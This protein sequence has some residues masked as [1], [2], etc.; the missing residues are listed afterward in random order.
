[1]PPPLR[2]R[3]VASRTRPLLLGHRGARHAAP[4]NTFAAFNL[5]LEEGADGVELDVR[6]NASGDVIVCHDLTL[7]R[8]TEG[9]DSRALHELTTR[10]CDAVRLAKDERLPHLV[11]VLDWAERH[12]ACVNVEIKSDGQR[13]RK[14]VRAVARLTEARAD[15]ENLLVSCFNPIVVQLHGLLAPS[16]PTAWLVD[17]PLL[18]RMPLLPHSGSAAIHPKESLINAES[19]ALWKRQGFRV[20]TWTVNDPERACELA[21]LGVDCL[22]SDN[23]GALKHAL[24]GASSPQHSVPGP[25]TPAAGRHRS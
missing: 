7:E 16:I 23:P 6:L 24:A 13:R 14:L 21:R 3:W 2:A 12:G 17:S 20:H 22:I 19:L 15:S 1:M 25:K 9:R 5:A 10:E 18:S 11:D 4:E 8:V